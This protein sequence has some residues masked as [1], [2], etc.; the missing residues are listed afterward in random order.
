MNSFEGT[1]DMIEFFEQELGVPYPWEKY[2]QVVVADFVAGGMENTSL[3]ILADRTLFTQATENVRSSEGLVSHELVHQWVGDYVTCK[4][5]S[6]VWLNE[7]FATYYQRLYN[8]HRNGR[9]AMLYDLYTAAQWITSQTD[10]RPIVN[11]RYKAADEQFD[12]RTYS[13]A[14]WVLHMPAANWETSCS[15]A[16]SRRTRS[17]TVRHRGDGRLRSIVEEL[18]GVW[19]CFDQCPQRR[20]PEADVAYNWS[21]TG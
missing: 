19:D 17:G 8:G 4:D 5:W 20:L 7:G 3:T 16:S 14:G 2:D 1:A 21:G 10:T 13:K 9:D 15:A 12:Y 6:H 11:R 18:S